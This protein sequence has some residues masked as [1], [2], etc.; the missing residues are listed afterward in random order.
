MKFFRG[1]MQRP[2]LDADRVLK[3]TVTDPIY[4]FIN[5]NMYE[6]N[7]LQLIRAYTAM[8]T[9]HDTR[10][11]KIKDRICY[12]FHQQV[13]QG[14]FELKKGNLIPAY[15]QALN[16]NR[17]TLMGFSEDFSLEVYKNESFN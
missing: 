9:Q 5:D 17:S 12:M 1:G 16:L 8:S 10:G 11:I 14:R 13:Q 2:Q 3:N 4:D 6:F 7:D 15:C